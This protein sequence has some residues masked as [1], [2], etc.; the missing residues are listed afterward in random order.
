MYD[1][2]SLFARR[3]R[4]ALPLLLLL[5]ST[6]CGVSFSESFDGT[7]LFKS[8]RLAG[9][10]KTGSELTLTLNVNQGYPVP[11][12]VACYYED[13][14]KLSDDQLK[15]AFQERATYIGGKELPAAVDHKPGDD[16]VREDLVFKFTIDEPG[17]YFL[18]CL[19]P[20][21]PE[22]GLGRLF[23]IENADGSPRATPT[24]GTRA[25]ID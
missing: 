4:L 11:V 17:E 8:V 22:N 10:L 15:L 19:T 23:E 20:A 3:L 6:G 21:A 12:Q 13:G 18:A 14:S 16:V 24:P 5:V 1:R 9:E 25:R 2:P 7:E